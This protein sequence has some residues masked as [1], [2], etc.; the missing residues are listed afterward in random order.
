MSSFAHLRTH[1]R[2]DVAIAVWPRAVLLD[3]EA[4]ARAVAHDLKTLSLEMREHL[5]T[6]LA[7]EGKDAQ[8][9]AAIYLMLKFSGVRPFVN[10][11]VGR[12]TEVNKIDDFRD[13]W[14]CA[15][16]EA[17]AV[18]STNGGAT[19]QKNSVSNG[20]GGYADFLS[21]AERSEAI[22]EMK[23]LSPVGPAPNYL[24]AQAIK[25]PSIK[26][27]DPRARGASPGCQG[28]ARWM[29]GRKDRGL[30]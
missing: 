10:A 7:A 24:V 21:R 16:G 25:W 12:G 27:E 28:Y 1:L 3:D 8:K 29:Q 18:A 23:R 19:A 15:I 13:N 26:P 6:Y 11:G 30:I 9:F 14:W 22:A 20:A 4:K 2:G 5:D 17:A